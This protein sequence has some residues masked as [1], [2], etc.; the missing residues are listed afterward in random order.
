[1]IFLAESYSV[2]ASTATLNG[3]QVLLGAFFSAS[4]RWQYL[5]VCLIIPNYSNTGA[6]ITFFQP[7]KRHQKS[8]GFFAHPL[9]TESDISD[10]WII[11][12]ISY[13]CLNLTT[14]LVSEIMSLD[15][16]TKVKKSLEVIKFNHGVL[17]DDTYM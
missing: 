9:V 10:R 16:K 13:Y 14:F 3:E 12:K 17:P 4:V 7:L 11:I 6:L 8:E 2:L 15:L 5:G 1:M